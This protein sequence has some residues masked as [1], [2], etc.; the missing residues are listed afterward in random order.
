MCDGEIATN[1]TVI[2]MYEGLISHDAMMT[3]KAVRLV[4]LTFAKKIAA[5]P[6]GID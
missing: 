2:V 4:A 1:K 5:N 3:D 6:P